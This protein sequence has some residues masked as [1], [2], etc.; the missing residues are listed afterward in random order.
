MCTNWN[1][2]PIQRFQEQSGYLPKFLTSIAFFIKF[3]GT[4]PLLLLLF[5]CTFLYRKKLKIYKNVAIIYKKQKINC[6]NLIYYAIICYAKYSPKPN[7]T[8]VSV[9][10]IIISLF[11]V[12][13]SW[14]PLIDTNQNKSFKPALRQ[15]IK[16]YHKTYFIPI[17]TY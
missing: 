17:L 14:V 12:K 9:A 15:C 2:C 7:L 10:I 13:L 11:L 3:S 6:C 16:R 5:N 8:K 4:S 1:G